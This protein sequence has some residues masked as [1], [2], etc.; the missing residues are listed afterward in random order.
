MKYH[1]IVLAICLITI[2][3]NIVPVYCDSTGLAIIAVRTNAVQLPFGLGPAG[4][5]GVG[6]QNED[7]TWT[8]GAVENPGGSPIVVDGFDNGGWTERYDTLSEVTAKFQSLGYD[9]IKVIKIE[10]AQP[11]QADNKIMYFPARGYNIDG[12]NCLDA[13][14]DVLRAYGA[15]DLPKMLLHPAPTDYYANVKGDEY[16][17]DASK[18]KYTNVDGGMPL[19]E[20]E[21][22]V[23]SPIQQSTDQKTVTLTVCVHS[24]DENGPA[25]PGAKITW[26]NPG[27]GLS[28][29]VLN[30]LPP[31][32][33]F[34]ATADNN[35]CIKSQIEPRVWLL[36]ASADGY[37]D[38]Q[39]GVLITE[40]YNWVA[41][42]QKK[43]S[44]ESVQ[45]NSESV[46]Q[47]PS[48]VTL[49][50]YV[51]DGTAIG[52]KISGAKIVGKDGSG[53]AFEK[54]TQGEG[55]VTIEGDP[56]TWSFK[57]SADGYETNSWDQE[58]TS[59]STKH[60]YLLP[61]TEIQQVST[62]EPP[63]DSCWT[64]N[65]T[66]SEETKQVSIDE[67]LTCDKTQSG[68][69]LKES[70]DLSA[71]SPQD[72]KKVVGKWAFHFIRKSWE[73]SDDERVTRSPD[74]SYEWDTTV[75]ISSD[76]TYTESTSQGTWSGEWIPVGDTI[77]FQS[78]NKFSDYPDGYIFTHK[79]SEGRDGRIEGN[80][81]S[82]KG[83]KHT[84]TIATG[85][86]SYTADIDET[87]SWS[88][89]RVDQTAY[90]DTAKVGR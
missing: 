58:I 87:Y 73:S 15:A 21:K 51:H 43:E 3:M 29:G 50:L 30:V 82:G 8:I 62:D 41:V 36:I 35:G 20:E 89:S 19:V 63:I 65:D 38:T 88:A 26:K 12:N 25:I 31:A 9:G 84:H 34:S 75:D 5:V 64:C 46:E 1:N 47:S 70:I 18:R 44:Q 77:R 33:K 66:Q 86:D 90:G 54:I 7:G 56:G 85:D 57:A 78:S 32:Q 42:L 28:A 79:V 40:D 76:G 16:L 83:S 81:M 80:T 59:T 39:R 22:S 55:S 6:F 69:T 72:A 53:N 67:C 23:S 52:P 4:H 74:L 61:I 48:Q 37:K 13:T 11:Q 27:S 24:G 10:N 71:P 14:V 49:T 2:F 45:S 68:E 60:A 17:W